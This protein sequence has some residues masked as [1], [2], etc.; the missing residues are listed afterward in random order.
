MPT[1][2]PSVT[3]FRILPR[4]ERTITS[5]PTPVARWCFDS[6]RTELSVYRCTRTVGHEGRHAH[7]MHWAGGAVLAVWEQRPGQVAA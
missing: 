3:V 7:I 2:T 1:L 6:T 4:P 5:A